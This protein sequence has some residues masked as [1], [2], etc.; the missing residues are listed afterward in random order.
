MMK[1]LYL[2]TCCLCIAS[3][4]PN[5]IESEEE[6][7]KESVEPKTDSSE[8]ETNGNTADC[9]ADNP[10]ENLPWLKELIEK[11]ETDRTGHY[12]GTV[13]L[14]SYKGKNIFVTDMMLGSGGIAYWFFNCAGNH[15]AGSGAPAVGDG[16]FTVEDPKDFAAFIS[17]LKLHEN[18]DIP[19]IYSNMPL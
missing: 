17:G 5:H 2:F 15:Y 8:P 19:V 6:N 12:R 4:N 1:Y 16:V 9:G 3:C 14:V 11:A 7:G 13:W 18:G 10:A